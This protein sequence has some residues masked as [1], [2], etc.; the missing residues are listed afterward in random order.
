MTTKN[1]Q[2]AATTAAGAVGVAR[3]RNTPVEYIIQV[4]KDALKL[5]SGTMARIYEA[6]HEDRFY[7]TVDGEEV[8]MTVGPVECNREGYADISL[9]AT[10]AIALAIRLIKHAVEIEKV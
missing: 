10:E 6:M 5:D 2:V 7:L 8:F 4:I 3:Q 9:T 1:D